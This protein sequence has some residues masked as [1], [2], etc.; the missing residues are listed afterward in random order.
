MEVKKMGLKKEVIDK[1]SSLLTAAFGL[2]AALAW[3]GAILAIFKEV[4]GTAES[5]PAMLTYA[6]VVTIIAVV[7]T[8]WISRAAAKI[9]L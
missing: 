7:V 6:I 3:N 2:V 9:K 8:I 1:M 5:I 4:F